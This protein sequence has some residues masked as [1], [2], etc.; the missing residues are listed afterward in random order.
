[1]TKRLLAAER[2][3]LLFSQ[4]EQLQHDDGVP[5]AATLRVGCSCGPAAVVAH[6]SHAL[7]QQ[8][9]QQQGRQLP[10]YSPG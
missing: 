6:G 7:K 1:V 5:P 3:Q 4:L 2:Q 10:I 9:Q 8:Q